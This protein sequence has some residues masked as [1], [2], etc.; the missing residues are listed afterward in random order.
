MNYIRETMNNLASGMST[1]MTVPELEEQARIAQLQAERQHV[2][3][4]NMET[5]LAEIYIKT[6][7]MQITSDY[8]KFVS[9]LVLEYCNKVNIVNPIIQSQL[10]QQVY[11]LHLQER[12]ANTHRYTV[13][14][15]ETINKFNMN[16]SGE[17]TDNYLWPYIK[18]AKLQ[19]FPNGPTTDGESNPLIVKCLKVVAAATAV[20]GGTLCTFHLLKN[21]ITSST[22]P[23]P[24]TPP[25]PQLANAINLSNLVNT[26]QNLVETCTNIS[27]NLLDQQRNLV[28]TITSVHSLEIS[29]ACIERLLN[30]WTKIATNI[31]PG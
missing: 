16:I 9:T 3:T 23:T 5:M 19:S 11:P 18:K 28:E 22:I 4:A 26:S 25:M 24:P 7:G 13:K 8:Q 29:N 20:V 1:F 17:A 14:Q 6:F 2:I 21:L 12:I 30:G 31:L 10:L 15:I 27:K